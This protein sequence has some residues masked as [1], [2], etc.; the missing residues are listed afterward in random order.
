MLVFP[1]YEFEGTVL[2]NGTSCYQWSGC[3]DYEVIDKFSIRTGSEILPNIDRFISDTHIGS[4]NLKA[5]LYDCQ[6]D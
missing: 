3:H 2:H 1:T 5:A 4:C 6:I